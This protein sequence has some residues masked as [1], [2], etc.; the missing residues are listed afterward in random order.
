[1]A[2]SLKDIANQI[3]KTLGIDIWLPYHWKNP[4]QSYQA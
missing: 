2:Y 4:Y 3:S 1:M